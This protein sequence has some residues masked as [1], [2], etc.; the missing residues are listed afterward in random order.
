MFMQP[1]EKDVFH[2]RRPEPGMGRNRLSHSRP[3]KGPVL[4][5]D[6]LRWG[7]VAEKQIPSTKRKTIFAKKN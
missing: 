6:E 4:F 2:T 7:K 3:D 1:K 5:Y